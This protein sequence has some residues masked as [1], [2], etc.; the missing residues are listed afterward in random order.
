ML[1]LGILGLG[2]GRSTMSAALATDKWELKTICDRNEA[3][4][5]QRCKEFDFHHY[6]LEYQDIRITSY[7]VCYTKLLRLLS[8]PF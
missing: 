6:T 2:E 3:L 8:M 7:N 5:K 4:C 1:R